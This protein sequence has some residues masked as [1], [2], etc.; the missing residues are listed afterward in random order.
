MRGYFAF[1]V[2]FVSVFLLISLYHSF[3]YSGFNK[4]KEIAIE[5]NYQL[6][7]NVK[8]SIL[9]AAD[10]AAKKAIFEYMLLHLGE[11]IDPKDMRDFIRARAFEGMKRLADFEYSEKEVI[12]WCGYNT[13]NELKNLMKKMVEE[14][15]ALICAD[16]KPIE[17]DECLDFVNLD[18]NLD[19]GMLDYIWLGAN[20]PGDLLKKGVVGVSVYDKNFG[21][22]GVSYIP[23]SEKRDL[24]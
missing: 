15:K 22:S 6:E 13:D 5:Q 19:D 20:D 16:C 14:K 3:A 4:A 12:I 9:E 21:V 17:S 18:I 1:L 2:V 7:L 11:A 23:Q 8:Y 10:Q 24:T